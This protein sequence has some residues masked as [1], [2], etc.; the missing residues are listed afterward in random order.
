MT[1][2]EIRMA[3]ADLGDSAADIRASAIKK[4]REEGKPAFF[5]LITALDSPNTL[6]RKQAAHAIRLIADDLANRLIQEN[7]EE[8]RQRLPTET[9]D[10]VAALES[11]DKSWRQTVEW[12]LSRRQGEA[13]SILISTLRNEFPTRPDR[14]IRIL[15]EWGDLRAVSPLLD[16][17]DTLGSSTYMV[18][19]EALTNLARVTAQHPLSLSED[20]MLRF[21]IFARQEL[22]ASAAPL[23]DALQNMAQ[24]RPSPGLRRF[25]PF[26]KGK[27]LSPVPESFEKAR[28]AILAATKNLADLPLPAEEA[29][30]TPDLP[31]PAD[32]IRDSS[33]LPAPVEPHP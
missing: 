9:K 8:R 7:E 30:Y 11:P 12:E 19:V 23:G 2:E 29:D 31:R 17:W 15:G 25:L 4:L 5:A 16:A 26:L 10:L 13:F 28:Q 27:W 22:G 18:I 24:L 33:S 3:V 20:E 1:S 32:P 21:I 14:I 6:Q